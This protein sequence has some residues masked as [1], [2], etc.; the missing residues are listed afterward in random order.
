MSF[1][2]IGHSHSLIVDVLRAI[3]S[4]PVTCHQQGPLR[5]KTFGS[6]VITSQNASSL[7]YRSRLFQGPSFLMPRYYTTQVQPKPVCDIDRPTCDSLVEEHV[8]P[9]TR[10]KFHKKISHK[11]ARAAS[12][13]W[14]GLKPKKAPSTVANYNWRI[15]FAIRD[16]RVNKALEY[17]REMENRDMEPDNATYN[18]IINGFCKQGD[19]ERAIKWYKRMAKRNVKATVH[20]YTSLI[21]GYMR[22]SNVDQAEETFRLMMKKKIKPTLVTYNI[23]MHHS[24]RQLDIDTA[25]KFWGNLLQAGLQPSVYTF[26]IMI[27]GFGDAGQVDE[28]WRLYELMQKHN[29]D[30]NTVVATT[31]MDMHTI[32]HDNQN[33]IRLFH[34]FFRKN[35]KNLQPSA[36]TRNV[37]L[38]AV[39]ATATKEEIKTYYDQFLTTLNEKQTTAVF[40]GPSVYTY[41]SFMR[42]FL[43]RDDL[44]MVS[45]VYQDMVQR[46]VKPTLVTYSVLMLAH[47]FV[48]DPEACARIL[49]ELKRNGIE[50]NVVLYTIVMRAWAK[51]GRWD[52]VRQVY[53]EM[54]QANIEPS[55]RTMEVLRWGQRS[56]HTYL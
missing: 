48:P 37:L 17:L 20:T 56:G 46:S 5:N 26:A 41:T 10:P 15:W 52:Q 44:A 8:A 6:F 47:A 18:L 7:P 49:D 51:S 45:Q 4:R 40:S 55:K 22:T 43:R 42:A 53:E 23:L 11:K 35:E 32:H 16:G 24:V 54:K 27:H 1:R 12:K 13:R 29:I 14:N 36:H 33:T 25:V 21:D 9:T 28:A 34:D 2:H 39:I 3:I 30:V 19:M 31:L 38:N 50:V